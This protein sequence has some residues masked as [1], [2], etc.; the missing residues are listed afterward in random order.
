VLTNCECLSS[1]HL[2][3]RGGLLEAFRRHCHLNHSRLL[4]DTLTPRENY[5]N[6]ILVSSVT[7]RFFIPLSNIVACERTYF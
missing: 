5:H 4:G 2:L 7:G 6:E 3:K 1:Q